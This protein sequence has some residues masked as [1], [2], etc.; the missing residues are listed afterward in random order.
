MNA[1]IPI[2]SVIIT[3]YNREK[4]IAEA[5]ESVLASIYTNFELIISDDASTDGTVPIA[6]SFEDRDKRV[7]VFINEYNLGD[8]P[9]RNKAASYAKGKYLKYVDSDDLITPD[10]LERMVT[11]ME[12][13]SEAAFG[14]SQFIHDGAIVYPQLLSPQMAYQQH[15]NGMELFSY[16]PVGAIIKKEVFDR[17][18]GFKKERYISDTEL[19]LKLASVYPTVKLQPGLVVWRQH[20]T[21]EYSVG[22]NS[23][24]Y[25][26]LTYPMDMSFLSSSGCPLNLE[27]IKKIK[28]RLQWKHAR[29]ILSLAF[30]KNKVKM[31]LVIYKESGLSLFQLLNGART[32]DSVKKSFT[33]INTIV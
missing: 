29:D 11:A 30:K 14:I 9:N 4:F 6:R 16:G 26:R 18:G 13:F 20:P 31:A 5:I 8:Y 27:E 15:Y 2:V 12:H 21:Q 32:Y 3:A 7:K 33:D 10:G 23:F 22:N 25:L 24:S 17:V 1:S 19:W 28:K